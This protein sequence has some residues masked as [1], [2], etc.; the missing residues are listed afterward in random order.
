MPEMVSS[1]Y[2]D[3]VVIDTVELFSLRESISLKVIL[4][5]DSH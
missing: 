1:R 4:G 3:I 5:T 2:V